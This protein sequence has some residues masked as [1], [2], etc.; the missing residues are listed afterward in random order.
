ME[1]EK[2]DIFYCAQR[3]AVLSMYRYVVHNEH[4][5]KSA[6]VSIGYCT[7]CINC[8]Y[9]TKYIMPLETN[10]CRKLFQPR[11]NIWK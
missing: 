6:L 8:I 1:T 4:D 5:V 3:A 11:I 10:E 7:N 9:Q 2:S